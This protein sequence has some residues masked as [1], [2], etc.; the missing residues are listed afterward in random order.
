M[1]VKDVVYSIH[2]HM[3]SMLELELNLVLVEYS[4]FHFETLY[5]H[6]SGILYIY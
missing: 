4:V 2:L 5:L 1:K 6:Y 3:T